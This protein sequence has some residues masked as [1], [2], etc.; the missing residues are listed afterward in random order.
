MNPP[1]YD[2][3]MTGIMTIRCHITATDI[4]NQFQS[5]RNIQLFTPIYVI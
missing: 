5:E 1:A 3:G 4:R 2:C